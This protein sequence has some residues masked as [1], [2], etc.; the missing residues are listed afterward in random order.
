MTEIE[1]QFINELLA[2]ERTRDAKQLLQLRERLLSD[3]AAIDELLGRWG[4]KPKEATRRGR[5]KATASVNG[6]APREDD[7]LLLTH[8]GSNAITVLQLA[9]MTGLHT[10]VVSAMI[11]RLRDSGRIEKVD[12]EKMGTRWGVSAATTP[13][14]AISIGND[15]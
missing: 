2:P 13:E 6:K 12:G 15:S 3:M 4:E 5:P 10:K 7:L 11:R 9:K 1:Q 14:A 8:M